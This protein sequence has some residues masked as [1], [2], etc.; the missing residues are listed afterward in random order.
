MAITVLGEPFARV[1]RVYDKMRELFLDLF[2][3]RHLASISAFG[4]HID[5]NLH[6]RT[7]SSTF[8]GFE[9]SVSPTLAESAS[10]LS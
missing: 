7:R 8:I 3:L 5:L 4:P 6:C 2:V 10:I 1:N 9:G